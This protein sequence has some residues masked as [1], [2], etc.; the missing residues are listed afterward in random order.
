[1]GTRGIITFR[2]KRLLYNFFVQYDCYFSG[3][4]K[5]LVEEIKKC[6]LFRNV[7]RS[8]LDLMRPFLE[9]DYCGDVLPIPE[10]VEQELKD[11]LAQLPDGYFKTFLSMSN[12]SWISQDH[13]YNNNIWIEYSY[14]ICLDEEVFH[15]VEWNPTCFTRWPIDEIPEDW[16]TIA[17]NKSGNTSSTVVFQ[18]FYS[19]READLSD[20]GFSSAECLEH[21]ELSSVWRV[22]ERVS[23]KSRVIKINENVEQTREI[24]VAEDILKHKPPHLVGV[25]KIL[26]LTLQ[27]G[28][29]SVTRKAVEME[30]YDG[31]WYTFYK[32]VMF[33][34]KTDKGDDYSTIFLAFIND[35]VSGIYELHELG[36]VHYDVK[37]KNI[38]YKKD[39]A[40]LYHFALCDFEGACRPRKNNHKSVESGSDRWCSGW[41]VFKYTQSYH[42]EILE[43]CPALHVDFHILATMI[44]KD[45]ADDV[46]FLEPI[47]DVLEVSDKDDGTKLQEIRKLCSDMAATSPN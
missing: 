4:G 7:W 28:T 19:D 33:P 30:C 42:S 10:S 47:L 16:E 34:L 43:R 24:T 25:A 35:V 11:L 17:E 21:S 36:Y 8:W 44:R 23:G 14:I 2:H 39:E 29:T 45:Y 22:I 31:D 38:L 27:H 15:A 46:N 40:G 20:A 3:V 41:N 18:S 9:E 5:N 1:M 13:D 32:T 6:G 12:R 26:E 37:P